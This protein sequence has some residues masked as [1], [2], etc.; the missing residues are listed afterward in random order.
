MTDL[1]RDGLESIT[2]ITIVTD[3]GNVFED[4]KAYVAGVELSIQDEGRTLKV[5]ARTEGID[6]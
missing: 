3:E 5:F 4:Y 2:R 6:D 1:I